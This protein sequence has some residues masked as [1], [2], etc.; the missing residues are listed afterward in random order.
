MFRY[1]AV[2]A[3]LV[4]SGCFDADDVQRSYFGFIQNGDKPTI[5]M[6]LKFTGHNL[7]GGKFCILSPDFPEDAKN[8][9]E[10][11]MKDIALV[12]DSYHFSVDLMNGNNLVHREYEALFFWMPEGLK[13]CKYRGLLTSDSFSEITVFKESH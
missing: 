4:I 7:I 13:S 12:G 8:G 3:F 10:Y 6:R 2:L 5:G 9:I 11:E 1:M